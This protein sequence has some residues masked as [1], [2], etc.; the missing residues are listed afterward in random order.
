MNNKGFIKTILIIIIALAILKI[1]WDIDILD[2]LNHPTVREIWEAFI[3]F[4][5]LIWNY[6][7]DIFSVF[8]K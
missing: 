6:I 8:G 7:K 1:V 4:L 2:L 5:K 3:N